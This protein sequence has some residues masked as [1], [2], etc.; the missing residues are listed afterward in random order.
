MIFRTTTATDKRFQSHGTPDSHRQ[1]SLTSVRVSS[2][3]PW[4]AHR[5]TSG[6]S[7]ANRG[8]RAEGRELRR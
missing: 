3:D 2:G 4:T 7:G 6:D 8:R 1:P 5:G